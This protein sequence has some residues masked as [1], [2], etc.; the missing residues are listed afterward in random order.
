M[1]AD[2][3]IGRTRQVIADYFL[4][5]QEG[6]IQNIPMESQEIQAKRLTVLIFRFHGIVMLPDTLYDTKDTYALG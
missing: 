4:T 1:V 6:R 5:F 3:D 2:I